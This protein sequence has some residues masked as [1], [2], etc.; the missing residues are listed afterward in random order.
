MSLNLGT[1]GVGECKTRKQ[2]YIRIYVLCV[3]VCVNESFEVRGSQVRP[4][5]MWKDAV[6]KG[7]EPNAKAKKLETNNR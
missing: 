6:K 2:M 7:C 3:C 4:R 5:K 1:G